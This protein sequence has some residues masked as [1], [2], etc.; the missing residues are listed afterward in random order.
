MTWLLPH[1][2]ASA[3]L[4]ALWL[5]LNT[6][7]SA[8]H[9]VLGSA[10]ALA[11]GWALH[12]LEPPKARIGRPGAILRL[13]SLVFADIVRSNVAVARIV[14]GLGGRERTSG[15]VNIPLDL[16]DPYGLAALA[17]IITS[18]PGTLWVKHDP[19]TGMLTIHVLDLIDEGDWLR[20]LKGRYE[21]L[22]LEIFE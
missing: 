19:L 14:L 4:L 17:C 11:G 13:F 1:P 20:T 18:T 15:F 2:L 16:R 7:M 6:T 12:A 22:L 21:R 10:V 9:I 8:A 5:L 3:V